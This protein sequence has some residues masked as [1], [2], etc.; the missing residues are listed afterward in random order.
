VARKSSDDD[1]GP[2][3]VAYVARSRERAIEGETVGGAKT[4]EGRRI[5]TE[6][7]VV[8]PREIAPASLDG[9]RARAIVEAEVRETFHE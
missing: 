8:G 2:L 4:G 3:A 9:I 1:A 6:I 5:T 7:G